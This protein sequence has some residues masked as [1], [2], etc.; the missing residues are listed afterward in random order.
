MDE[1]L[2]LISRI[3]TDSPPSDEE[4]ATAREE[5]VSL[6]RVA[7]AAETR[8]LESAVAIREAIDNIDAEV[9]ARVEAAEREEAEARRLLEGLGLEDAEDD[10]DGE[11][12]DGDDSDADADAST[13]AEQVPVAASN[14]SSRRSS[15]S[16][17]TNAIRRTSARLDRSEPGGSQHTRVL[18][19]GAAQSEQLSQNATLRD[20]ARIFDRAAGRVKQ[21]GDRQS[22]VRIEWD[23][24]EARRLFG[25]EKH[26]ND[27]I[28]DGIA[29]PEAIAAAGGVCDPLP[30][31][32]THPIL[33]Q[34]G[35]PIR[36]ALPRF[37]ASRGGV[38]FSPTATIAD[39]DGAVGVWDYDTDTS[40][41][42]NEKACLTLSCEDEVVAHVD[43]VTA[44]LQIGNYQARFNPEFWRSRLQLLMVLH[45]RIA[46]QALYNAILAGSTA[47]TYGS[48]SGTI[49]SV[50]SA[51]DKAVAGLRSRHRL[52]NTVIRMIAPEWVHQALRADI[53]SQRLGSSPADA[54]SVAD[55]VINSFF[56]ARHVRPVW[57]QDIEVFGTQSAG[58]LLDFP[59]NDVQLVLF[60]EGTF[61]YM[62]GGT[63]DL[64][65][66]IVDSTLI[67]QNNRM[68]FLETFEKA[69]KR[70]GES[71]RITVPINE[72]CVCP[73]VLVTSP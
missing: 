34:R 21:R 8:D 38:R 9:K 42:E 44:C 69:V 27:R 73:E 30:A 16:S 49:Y 1:L 24:P 60:P 35:R 46:E 29:A 26:D 61:F 63:L 2:E 13:E 56:A 51:V 19:L 71:L 39:L 37:Q 32:F 23:Y 68:A 41:G 18:T 67:A 6:L 31:D 43:A 11:T 57:S 64:G 59:N 3:G 10:D 28:L 47:V 45:D 14:A 40:P 50:L 7:T 52:G 20:V 17:L 53:A 55:N 48:G 12:G 33:G 54:L 25:T 58:S 22:L 5:L 72:L 62:D 70:G 36:D 4:L 65:T 66:E 15:S